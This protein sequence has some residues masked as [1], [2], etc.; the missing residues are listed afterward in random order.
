MRISDWSSD[1]C[2]SDLLHYAVK[3]NPMPAVVQHLRPQVDGFDVASAREMTAALDAGMDAANIAFAGPGKTDAEPMQ[4]LAAGILIELESEGELQRLAAAAQR[5]GYPARVAIRINPDFVLKGSG[6]RM[7]GG[8]QQFGV[9][10]ERSEEHTS[11]LQSLMR[12]SYA[13]FCLKK[14]KLANIY[15]HTLTY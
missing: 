15:C 3:A 1:V 4:A 12:T 8:A 5:S 11:E 14:K 9:D 13:V 10:A 6:M 2:S 7:G